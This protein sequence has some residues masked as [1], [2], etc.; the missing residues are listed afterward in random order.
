MTCGPHF[1]FAPAGDFIT[2][3]RRTAWYNNLTAF[4]KALQRKPLD[5]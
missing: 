5:A 4:S 2:E 3:G 1:V